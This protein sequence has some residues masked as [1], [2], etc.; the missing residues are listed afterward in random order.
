MNVAELEPQLRR[1][2]GLLE[3][4]NHRIANHLAIAAGM[5]GAQMSA[6]RKGPPTLAREA[7]E[8]ILKDTANRIQGIARLHRR[9]MQE[10]GDGTVEIGELLV[11]TIQQFGSALSLVERLSIRHTLGSGC[12]LHARRAHTLSLIV[13]E[14]VLNAAKHAHPT[15]VPI[16]MSVVCASPGDGTITV[17]IC[18]DGI[19]L[20]EGFDATRDGGFGFGLIR[21]LAHSIG[22]NLHVESDELGLCFRMMFDADHDA[23]SWMKP[24]DSGSRCLRV[25]P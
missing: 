21:N 11:D 23:E 13:G 17:E 12:F 9:L 20:P 1:S 19:G 2:P 24:S 6:L 25:V 18:D 10:P 4:A 7:A 5:V 16:E 3:E 15:G 8:Q 14:I 22:A